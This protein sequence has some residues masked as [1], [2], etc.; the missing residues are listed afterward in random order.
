MA[1]AAPS[2]NLRAA[3]IFYCVKVKTARSQIA[4]W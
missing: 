3:V 4:S 2:Q 1:K